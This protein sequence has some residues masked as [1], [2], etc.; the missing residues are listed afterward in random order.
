M[1]AGDSWELA[2]MP[3][4]IIAY[5]WLCREMEAQGLARPAGEGIYPIWAWKQYLGS[6]KP[7][8]DLRDSVMKQWGR[9]ERHVLLTLD[10][11]DDEVILHDYEAWH[12]PLNHWYLGPAEASEDFERR[13]DQAGCPRGGDMPLAVLAL[14]EEL[15]A[16]WRRIFDLDTVGARMGG[17]AFDMQI[18]QATFWELRMDQIISA[19]EFG[20]D[21]PKQL[22]PRRSVRVGPQALKS[23]VAT[24][25]S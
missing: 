15:E 5:D 19:V 14:R 6:A 17:G 16:S 20:L 24:G 9:N 25:E 3:A 21:R 23:L 8:P 7:K 4:A 11:P 10:V 18:I 13:C 1:K 12:Y 2:D 22:L